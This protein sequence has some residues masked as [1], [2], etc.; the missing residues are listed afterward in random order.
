[1]CGSRKGPVNICQQDR[2]G[3]ERGAT[4][5][6]S[7]TKTESQETEHHR[8]PAHIQST[9]ALWGPSRSWSNF[10]LPCEQ[11]AQNPLIQGQPCSSLRTL[12]PDQSV[13]LNL[14]RFIKGQ[15]EDQTWR[16]PVAEKIFRLRSWST[17]TQQSRRPEVQQL[18]WSQNHWEDLTC[19]TDWSYHISQSELHHHPPTPSP[20]YTD[21]KTLV[22]S[23]P[24]LNTS[25]LN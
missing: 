23:L 22:H 2:G 12:D 9:P 20:N 4:I 6:F 19:W 16:L 25:E 8:G 21:H 3:G 15:C 1:M 24:T 18:V 13:R 7:L 10:G 11:T 14:N 17:S 5:R